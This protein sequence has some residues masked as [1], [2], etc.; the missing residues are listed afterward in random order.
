MNQLNSFSEMLQSN[1]W[2]Y[3]IEFKWNVIVV[4]F[5]IQ[6]WNV[7][8]YFIYSILIQFE[9]QF[10]IENNCNSI[11]NIEWIKL[12]YYELS[13]MNEL[14]YHELSWIN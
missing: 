5:Q 3:Q 12:K 4:W 9:I 10:S 2:L 13:W 8:L 11:E 7:K 1:I 6:E 14:N